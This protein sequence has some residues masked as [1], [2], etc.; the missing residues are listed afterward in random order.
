MA[1]PTTDQSP[2][3]VDFLPSLAAIQIP[4]ISI[5]LLSGE[6]ITPYANE[7]GSGTLLGK[8]GRAKI[9]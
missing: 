2:V 1:S 7:M 6:Q 5:K 8:R 3:Q 9:P 4:Q